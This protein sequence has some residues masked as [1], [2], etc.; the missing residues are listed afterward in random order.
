MDYVICHKSML[1]STVNALNYYLK[2]MLG[3]NPCDNEDYP[4]IISE[5]H[6]DRLTRYLEN[7][8]ILG[9][10]TYN[11]KTLKISPTFILL[12]DINAPIMQEEIFGPI[13]PI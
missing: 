6:F 4:R 5:K 10:G 9:G 11:R 3:E 2:E 8:N 1:K 12:E 13:L 7:A